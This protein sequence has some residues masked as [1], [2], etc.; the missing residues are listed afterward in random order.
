MNEHV[1]PIKFF[2]NMRICA[3]LEVRMALIAIYIVFL[4]SFDKN[5]SLLLAD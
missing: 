1:L 2:G 5:I 3:G 4:F